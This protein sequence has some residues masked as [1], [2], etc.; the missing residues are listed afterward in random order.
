MLVKQ[1]P[2]V[3][4]RGA[5]SLVEATGREPT[6]HKCIRNRERGP[7]SGMSRAGRVSGER[8]QARPRSVGCAGG[9]GCRWDEDFPASCPESLVILEGP[10]QQGWGWG[11]GVSGPSPHTSHSMPGAQREARVLLMLANHQP[12]SKAGHHP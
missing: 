7:G 1:N 5:Y 10:W 12:V 8:T 11:A 2:S 3:C 9:G 6:T 4:P